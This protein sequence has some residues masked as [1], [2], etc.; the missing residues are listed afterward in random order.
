MQRLEVS[1]AVRPIYGSLGFKRLNWFYNTCFGFQ[2]P[3]SYIRHSFP[4]FVS[5]SV[6]LPTDLTS[7]L[8][9]NRF[10][11]QP[12]NCLHFVLSLCAVNSRRTVHGC[13]TVR[14]TRKLC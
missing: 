4:L 3:H 2:F 11:P 14:I 10:P 9:L 13:C 8:Q 7:I 6:N 12:L 5:K 1:G